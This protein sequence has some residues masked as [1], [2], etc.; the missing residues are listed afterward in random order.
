MAELTAPVFNIVHGSSIDGWGVRTTVFLKGCPLRCLW[1]C[2]PEGQKAEI[3]LKYTEDDCNGCGRCVPACPRGAIRMGDGSGATS[4]DDG[5]GAIR[6]GDGSGAIRMGDGSGAKAIVD[7][8]LCDN[9]LEC[10]DICYVDALSTFAKL[11]SVTGLFREVEKDQ[12]YFG[13]D[14]GVTIGGGEAT[15]HPEFT[16]EFIQKCKKAYIHTALDTCGHINTET[17][18]KCLEEADLVLFDIKGLDPETHKRGTGADNGLILENLRYRDSLEKDII[19]RLPLIPGF[20]D[21][22]ENLER[23]ADLIAGMKS[24][25]R[26]DIIPFHKYAEVKYRQLGWPVPFVFGEDFPQEREQ[27]ALDVF[28]DAGLP[29]QLGG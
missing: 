27:E 5:P 12:G 19:I 18:M 1:C 29:A 25:K 10:T 4:M 26:I 15:L 23:E 17:G 3:E 16:Y 9:C 21:P 24:V 22:K 7:R 14:G 20:T 11:Y 28:L 6:M 13:V 2:N 8:G